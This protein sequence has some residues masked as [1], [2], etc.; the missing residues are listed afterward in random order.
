MRYKDEMLKYT[1][2]LL[3]NI[4]ICNGLQAQAI[5]TNNDSTRI[6]ELNKL[7]DNQKV[8][9][10]N[11]KQVIDLQTR[12]LEQ[13]NDLITICYGILAIS[14]ALFGLVIYFQFIRP[15]NKQKVEI[16][17]I[18]RRSKDILN[19]INGTWKEVVE[20]NYNKYQNERLR[21]VLFTVPED[22]QRANANLQVLN[23]IQTI[24]FTYEQQLILKEYL[25]NIK[26]ILTNRPYSSRVNFG[27]RKIIDSLINQGKS[28]W[29]EEV[30]R[31]YFNPMDGPV[32]VYYTMYD[33]FAE[34][35]SRNMKSQ[36][37]DL[38]LKMITN[39]H[40]HYK[41]E[42]IIVQR[43][44]MFLN[45]LFKIVHSQPVIAAK[46]LDDI[47]F[48]NELIRLEILNRIIVVHQES[49]N[50]QP[51]F[52]TRTEDLEETYFLAKLKELED[53]K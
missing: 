21:K 17:E 52:G 47:Y 28:E 29:V 7:I 46:I 40:P 13:A 44:K 38:V 30:F 35:L 31:N 27:V 50:E 19:N 43:T 4:L 18:N 5:L 41:E 23:E 48:V 22:D 34:Y 1:I 2:Y 36:D 10:E 26:N 49:N 51:A 24:G 6:I 11:A 45:W 3:L 33:K 20:K 32:F 14:L 16:D 39:I 42:Q 53:S 15:I 8:V 37:S 9:I 25:L 12:Q